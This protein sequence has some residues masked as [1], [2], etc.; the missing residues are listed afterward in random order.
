MTINNIY[1]NSTDLS[2]SEDDR[3]RSHYVRHLIQE[4]DRAI[5]VHK[6]SSIPNV[7]LQFWDNAETIPPDVRECMNSW[8]PLEKRGFRRLLFDDK[9]ATLFITDNFDSRYLD[10]FKLCKHPAMR[11][12]YFR[13][14]YL[15][16]NGGFYVDADDVYKGGDINNW[17]VD[18]MLKLQL[19]CYNSST[20]SM[21]KTHDFI[22]NPRNLSELTFYVNNDPIIAPANHP[23]LRMALERS[24][25]ILLSQIKQAKQ[26]IQSTTGPGN[27]SASLVLYA[28]KAERRGIPRNF[29]FLA[30]W[31]NVSLPKWPLSYRKDNR[32][33]RLWDG[34]DV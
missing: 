13:L 29:V 8:K 2:I 6:G 9:L 32:N 14:C 26:E 30:N 21:V 5:P 10:A 34:R 18:N 28:I 33:W 20:D 22:N 31:D 7:L 23:V 12:D 25:K 19:L 16:I 4:K 1:R 24:T 15:V 3:L 11:A 27:L 17:F